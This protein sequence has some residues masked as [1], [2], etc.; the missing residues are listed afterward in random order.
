ML[1]CTN[2]NIPIYHY[3]SPPLIVYFKRPILRGKDIKRYKYEFKGY[4][5]IALLTSKN[6]NIDDYPTIKEYL[7]NNFGMEKLEQ[8]GKTYI[9][10]GKIIKSRKKTNN[11]WYETQDSIS[12]WNFFHKQPLKLY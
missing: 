12:Y 8:T 10:D 3:S 5:L 11:K 7:L 4:Y 2:P 6:Y 1:I 9:K